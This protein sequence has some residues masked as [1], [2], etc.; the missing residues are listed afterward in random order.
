MAYW[1]PLLY[2]LLLTTTPVA[3]SYQCL[4][5][6]RKGQTTKVFELLASSDEVSDDVIQLV[7]DTLL[8]S[9]LSSKNPDIQLAAL[10]GASLSQSSDLV[11]YAS[12]GLQSSSPEVQLAALS[13]L[14]SGNQREAEQFLKQALL[15][16]FL[17]IRLESLWLMS[18][19]RMASAYDQLE[20]LYAK[21][22]DEVRAVL[23]PLFAQEASSRSQDFLSHVLRSSSRELQAPALYALATI[24]TREKSPLSNPPFLDPLTLESF[25]AYATTH[26][27]SVPTETIEEYT[28]HSNEYVRIAALNVLAQNNFAYQ[29]KLEALNN[30]FALSLL[31]E[32]PLSD[33]SSLY[34]AI[35]HPDED[36]R[37]NAALALLSH[38]RVESLPVILEILKSHSEDSC[39]VPN[40]SP[41]G[42]MCIWLTTPKLSIE[43]DNLLY[44]Q[45]QSL[46]FREQV[47]ASS[48]SLPEK[49]FLQ[50][51]DCVAQSAPDLIPLL[52]NLLENKNSEQ[53]KEW[54]KKTYQETSS[55]LMHLY[56]AKSLVLLRED[57]P[58]N[59]ALIDWLESE[60]GL[61]LFRPRPLLPWF[62]QPEPKL[63]ELT[64][65]ERTRLSIEAISALIES[66]EPCCQK[67]I[68]SWMKETDLKT[69]LLLAGLLMNHQ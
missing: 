68:L 36:I 12:F 53:A 17:L 35:K 3:T 31:G 44:A 51:A 52:S 41:G 30:P 13:L 22:P 39:L 50:V 65:D 69:Q 18:S 34:K 45:E 55:Q 25:L 67:L 57:G 24:P 56:A 14:A 43:G 8:R 61:Q 6:M 63:Q 29:E 9:G 15:S 58:W 26:K 47:L 27:D 1:T 11:H 48:L 62:A 64:F 20:A 38:K 23:L 28:K 10:F 66:D 5:L 16:D 42:T 49:Q 37:I 19:L 4:N 60:K 54:L 2:T 59:K 21:L 40:H 32:L 46:R 7:A 33:K